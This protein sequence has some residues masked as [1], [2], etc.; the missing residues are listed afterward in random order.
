MSDFVVHFAKDCEG[1]DAYFNM[2][3]ILHSR[4][5]LAKN[6]FG[7]PGTYLATDVVQPTAPN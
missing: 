7:I 2:L 1:K 6:R 3:G 5:V 4:T